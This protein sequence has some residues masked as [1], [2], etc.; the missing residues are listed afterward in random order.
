MEL[1]PNKPPK[2]Q[3][4]EGNEVSSNLSAFLNSGIYHLDGSNVVF[5]DP[6][7][8]LNGCY[9]RFRLSGSAYY[10]RSFK[11]NIKAQAVEDAIDSS[12]SKKKKRKRKRNSCRVL[13]ERETAAE[14]RHQGVRPL[15]LNAH[16]ALLEVTDL[17][18]FLPN[19]MKGEEDSFC[20]MRGEEQNFM[21][22]ASHSQSSHYEIC[23]CSGSRDTKEEGEGSLHDY[24]RTVPLFSNLISNHLTDEIECEF[25]SRRYIVPCRSCFYTSDLRQVRDLIPAQSDLGFNLIVIDPPWENGSV[26]Q[27]AMYPTLP[28]RYFLYLPVKELA[29]SEGA[30]VALW[31]TNREK[32]RIFVE[33]ELFPAWGVAHVTVLYWLKVKPDGSLIGE[34]DLFHHRPYESLLVGYVNT[35]TA[36]L[37]DPPPAFRYLQNNQV[38]ISIPGAY[39]RKPPL[40]KLIGDHIPGPK[41]AKCLELF[42]REL[43]AGWTSWGNEPLRFQDAKYFTEK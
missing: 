29:H 35:K 38:F 7:R 27:K 32:H 5:V 40:G 39:S 25:L 1:N 31:M 20:D 37:E 26:H 33:K 2:S 4:M 12:N 43:V 18:R 6:V 42:A 36:D 13:N 41:P 11:S 10:S 3:T 22:L 23:L 15:L 16:N 21:D 9:T 8:I 34:L 30:L 24:G 28:N 19:I 17:L 14:N